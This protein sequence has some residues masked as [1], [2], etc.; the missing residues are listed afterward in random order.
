MRFLSPDYTYVL[1]YANSDA[2]KRS[3]QLQEMDFSYNPPIECR[4]VG[5][6]D[7][8]DDTNQFAARLR[9][10]GRYSPPQRVAEEGRRTQPQGP[11]PTQRI[12]R[13]SRRCVRDRKFPSDRGLISTAA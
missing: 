1:R 5:F 7:F 10:N 13:I 4:F 9:A 2:D 11:D 6:R 8:Q 3:G 12:S